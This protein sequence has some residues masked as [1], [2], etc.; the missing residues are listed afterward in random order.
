[1][2]IIHGLYLQE[3]HESD[4]TDP[5][6]GYPGLHLDGLAGLWPLLRAGPGRVQV[7]VLQ[8]LQKPQVHDFIFKS[9]FQHRGQM[10]YFVQEAKGSILLK[11]FW[12]S[13]LET[14]ARGSKIFEG[15]MSH[16][17]Y[18]T[19]E[20]TKWFWVFPDTQRTALPFLK[21]KLWVPLLVSRSCI[22][23]SVFSARRPRGSV[24]SKK[25]SHFLTREQGSQNENKER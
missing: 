14:K 6:W 1:M 7:R 21:R 22:E 12:V 24:I 25:R 3:Q 20:D 15:H 5:C 8:H 11:K 10:C 9:T 2:I 23:R 4:V 16:L 17:N 18:R 13:I 19:V